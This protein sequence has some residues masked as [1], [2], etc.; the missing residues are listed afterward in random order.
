MTNI[1][2]D[3]IKK[4]NVIFFEKWEVTHD[5]IDRRLEEILLLK[6]RVVD[7]EA[8]TGL[9]QTALQSCQ[10]TIAGMEESVTKLTALVTQLGRSVCRC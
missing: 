9:Q 7:L 5:Q 8:L 10:N 1:I 2:Q 4:N 3:A 6:N